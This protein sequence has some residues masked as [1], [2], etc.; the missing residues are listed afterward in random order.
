MGA[1]SLSVFTEI[2][3]YSWALYE[4]IF[5]ISWKIISEEM[6]NKLVCH[7]LSRRNY[8]IIIN[9]S[10]LTGKIFINCVKLVFK[11]SYWF[12]LAILN[13]MSSATRNHSSSNLRWSWSISIDIFIS[14]KSLEILI[15]TYL[16]PCQTSDIELLAQII[17]LL[18][19]HTVCFG[20]NT[21][22]VKNF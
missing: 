11:V 16:E 18:S 20:G 22:F 21:H 4:S 14:F 5:L 17:I 1:H 13:T 6:L 19:L 12:I 9:S 8:V 10:A 7:Q 3:S 15:K 2:W